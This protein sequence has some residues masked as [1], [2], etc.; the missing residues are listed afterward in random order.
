MIHAAWHVNSRWVNFGCATKEDRST[1]VGNL[2]SDKHISDQLFSLLPSK[3]TLVSLVFVTG[4]PR[5]AVSSG[6]CSNRLYPSSTLVS[7]GKCGNR[8]SVKS[9]HANRVLLSWSSWRLRNAE[10]SSA[11]PEGSANLFWLIEYWLY[12]RRWDHRVPT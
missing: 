3:F 5:P 11:A 8:Y 10:D 6:R 9:V 12:G 7:L 2:T 1:H 4:G